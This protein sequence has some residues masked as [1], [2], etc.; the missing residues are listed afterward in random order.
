MKRQ[1]VLISL[2]ATL[3]ACQAPVEEASDSS[4]V[5]QANCETVRQGLDNF[6]NEVADYSNYAE[7]YWLRNTRMN[8]ERGDTIRVEDIME[9]NKRGWAKYDYELISEL[10]FLPGV[11]A[12]TKEMDGSVRYYGMW[13]VTKAATDSTA[14]ASVIIPI[15]SSFDFDGE[16]KIL[17]QQNFGDFTAA[18]NSLN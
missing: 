16:G 18:F 6:Q 7:G 5:F 11:N 10:S 1:L 15:Y 2:G 4:A 12:D 3:A 17:F 9:S 8:P 14:E 13:K